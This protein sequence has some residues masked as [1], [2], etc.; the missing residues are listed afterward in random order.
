VVSP[1]GLVYGRIRVVQRTYHSC[2]FGLAGDVGTE[3]SLR[4]EG[5]A[6]ANQ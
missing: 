5:E 2:P 4:M 3:R 1:K 6:V